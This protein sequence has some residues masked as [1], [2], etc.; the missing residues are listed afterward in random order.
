MKLN[1]I[2]AGVG[3]QGTVL[4]AQMLGSAVIRTARAKGERTEVVVGEMY[5]AAMRGGAVSSHVRIEGKAPLTREDNGDLILGLEPMEALR[6][7]TKCLSPTGISIINT[8]PL[9]PLDVK[10]G[11]VKY[12]PVE[13][14]LNVLTGLGSKV[15]SF[16]ATELASKAGSPRS[17]NIVMLGSL[18]A[19]NKLP[20]DKE[21]MLAT[22]A[23]RVPANTKD[24]NFKA[25]Q[26]G[27]DIQSQLL[28]RGER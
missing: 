10:L 22:I 25:F 18:F 12:P 19:L 26:L 28:A 3:G 1:V 14:I 5:G 20:V 4:V 23:E 6:I 21:I 7:A 2:I 17:M 27:I 15:F 11:Q 9:F 16:D 13:E 8:R 24:A